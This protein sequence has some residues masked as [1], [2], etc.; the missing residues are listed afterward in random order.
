LAEAHAAVV[1]GEAAEPV[2][3]GIDLRAPSVAVEADALDHEDGRAGAVDAVCEGA[4]AVVEAKRIT[5]GR[6][7]KNP[8]GGPPVPV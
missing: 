7:R 8:T 3:E 6:L 2:G 4:G 1:E 5:Q